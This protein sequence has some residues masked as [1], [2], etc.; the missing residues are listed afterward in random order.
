MCVPSVGAAASAYK[1]AVV[2]KKE[3]N[4]NSVVQIR[5]VAICNT[6]R[7]VQILLIKNS[8]SL[9]LSVSVLLKSVSC[10]SSKKEERGFL[11]KNI[12]PCCSFKRGGSKMRK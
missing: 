9:S 12:L 1:C 5:H 6:N 10:D 2:N 3:R 8:L 7:V 4:R 11:L